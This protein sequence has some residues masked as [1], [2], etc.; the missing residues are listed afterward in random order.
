[1]HN[2]HGYFTVHK[3]WYIIILYNMSS[4]YAD[5]EIV[6]NNLDEIMGVEKFAKVYIS[7]E[8]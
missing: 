2:N 1:M 4:E 3:D 7:P 8:K 5:D 6:Q